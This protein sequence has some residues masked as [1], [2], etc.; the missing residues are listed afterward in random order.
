[1]NADKHKYTLA[2]YLLHG[3]ISVA[4]R[5]PFW[6]LYRMADVAF[7]VLYHL[8]RYRRRIVDR[9][10]AASFPA[11]S[12]GEL[13]RVRRRFYRNFADYI[14]E[15]VKLA[16]IS[17]RQIMR[18]FRFENVQLA[19]RFLAQGQP[20]VVYFAH[21]GNWEWATSVGLWCGAVAR[22]C[23]FGQVYRPLKNKVIDRFMLQI[24][25]RFDTRC[26][27]KKSVF[28]DLWRARQN[29]V[30]TMTGFMSDQKPSHGDRV[31]IISFLDHPTAVITGT[32]T[33][34][35]R[36]GAAAV[37]WDMSKTSRGRYV[38]TMRKLSDDVSETPDFAVTDLYFEML[39]ENIRREPAIW[40]W[41][42]NR[43]KRPVEM[44]ADSQPDKTAPR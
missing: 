18:R 28:R 34:A 2:D 4:S 24:R 13:K 20:V 35:R 33:V 41:T 16:H 39:Q 5:L 27:P 15:T 23:V 7:V 3:L 22:R 1:M 21:T 37:Y 11:M 9:N 36:L 26:Y 10:L 30:T 42:H 19:E 12:A 29:G 38:V 6:A 25:S 44:P 32:E 17:D 14:F 40:L 8:V 43:W 31:H